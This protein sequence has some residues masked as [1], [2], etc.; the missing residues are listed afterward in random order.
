[1]SNI[2]LQKVL[3]NLLKGEDLKSIFNCRFCSN[4]FVNPVTLPCGVS[5][6]ESHVPEIERYQCIYCDK[7][8]PE[9]RLGVNDVLKKM[10]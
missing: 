8:H 1:M 4:L 2:D 6:C 7:K 5:V 3:R 9:I 10:L